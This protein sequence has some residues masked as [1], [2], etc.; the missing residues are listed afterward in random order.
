MPDTRYRAFAPNGRPIIG[1]F[2][3]QEGISKVV[4]FTRY[5]DPKLGYEP[6]YS[7]SGTKWFDDTE[8]VQSKEGEDL[9]FDDE[10]HTWPTSLL[11]FEPIND[12]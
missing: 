12:K 10:S 2:E 8:Q 11:R 3:R 5:E 7:S 6:E 1:S 4:H 9:W